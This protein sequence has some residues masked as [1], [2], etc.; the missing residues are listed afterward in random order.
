MPPPSTAG[1][2]VSNTGQPSGNRSVKVFSSDFAQAFTTG[3]FADGYRLTRV[4][5]AE[6][7]GSVKPDYTVSI[8]S[9]S[10]GNPGSFPWAR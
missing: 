8:R 7:V 9:D 5:V 2:L 4:D 10:S 6:R 3:S 1:G